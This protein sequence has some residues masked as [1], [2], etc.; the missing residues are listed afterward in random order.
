MFKTW[1]FWVLGGC[2]GGD[3]PTP[4][5]S[6][7][8][9][10]IT[11]SE[12]DPTELM[13]PDNS[14]PDDADP[15]SEVALDGPWRFIGSKGGVHRYR[16]PL[17]FRT[18]ALFFHR[19]KPG[20]EVRDAAGS[21]RWGAPSGDRPGWSH[22][23]TQLTVAMATKNPPTKGALHLVYPGATEREAHLNWRGSPTSVAGGT[24]QDFVWTTVQDGW[25]ARR[26]LLLPA[27]GTIAW[28]LDV[29]AAGE[30]RFNAGLV[31][32]E[33]SEGAVR[34]NGARLVVEV[35]AA[36][37]THA[38]HSQDLSPGAWTPQRVD[39]SPWEG[40]SI[41][42]RVRSDP[43][44]DAVF[45]YAFLAGPVVASRQRQPKRVVMV[46]VDTLRP[47]RMSLYGYSRATTAQLDDAMEGAAVFDNA[48]SVAPW[49]L[50]SARSIVTGRHPE[51]YDIS[52]TLQEHLRQRGWASAFLAG[53]VYLSANFDMHRDWG[54]HRVGLWPPATDI[55]DD[56]LAWLAEH[57]GRDAIL[58]VH[59]MDPHLPYLEPSTYR[60]R[61]AG[62]PAGGLG[63]EFHLPDVRKARLG[64]P[65]QE[66]GRTY[67]GD[68]YDNN[69]RY[70]T[71]EIARLL[72]AVSD[73]DIVLLF[74]D[75]GEELWDH[76]G[77]EHGHTLYDELLR[78]PLAIRAPGMTSG[79][80]SSPVSLLD[81][82]PTVLDLLQVEPMGPMDGTSLVA[83]ASGERP[84]VDAFNDRD[85]AF[86][87]PLYGLERWGVLHGS[88]KWTT[89]DGGHQLFD[90]GVDPDEKR[91]LPVGPT[92]APWA[93]RLGAALGRDADHGWR[94]VPTRGTAAELWT[95]CVVR[96]GFK[97]TWS[98][99]EPLDRAD[100]AAR[101]ISDP[102]TLT[103]QLAERGATLDVGTDPAA[104]A[105][106]SGAKGGIQEVYLVPKLP[107]Q[108]VQ[109]SLRC[110]VTFNGEVGVLSGPSG[111]AG[112]AHDLDVASFRGRKLA[113]RIGIGP[114]P[115]D[116][117]QP[118][119]GRD[120][121]IDDL[122]VLLG[123]AEENAPA[124]PE[125]STASPAPAPD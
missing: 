34:S 44:G 123:Y 7:H 71:D 85:L 124:T 23:K 93:G 20:L 2:T 101:V 47:D 41:T 110:V 38:V 5:A 106:W 97:A 30:L 18:R 96:G 15:P 114:A 40:E 102:S 89:H 63:E 62:D 3:L 95:A 50:P 37:V 16:T 120:P 19:S 53:N 65:D 6:D 43:Q 29:P 58:Q 108:E 10:T 60:R 42:L 109:E 66:A 26:G 24:Q 17:P 57:E 91:P 121:A 74:A 13:I 116:L 12:L 64:R 76:G 98:G 100:A 4:V 9:I 75:H 81:L 61:Y 115:S 67:V 21:L 70:A 77:F 55:T 52:T 28:T 99:D 103:D 72:E 107:R 36:G 32:P 49:T 117:T 45:D 56:A 105:V 104:V 68:R 112:A 125:P 35:D 31:E 92:P 111:S 48:R 78:V 33:I 88:H 25:D 39:L 80:V 8:A 54:L 82:T 73:D 87:R 86:G 69:V 1:L 14:R 113:L 51:Y 59:Y 79:R 27:P 90:L 94:L 83:L 46:F 118:L 119:Q 84:A 11:L 22:N 122:L